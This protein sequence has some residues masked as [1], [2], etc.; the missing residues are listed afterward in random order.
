MHNLL[1]HRY[2]RS[3]RTCLVEPPDHHG[4]RALSVQTAV[5]SILLTA[6]ENIMLKLGGTV[7]S[8]HF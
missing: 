2:D 3:W 1:L 7:Q 8:G 4:G 6:I 5:C